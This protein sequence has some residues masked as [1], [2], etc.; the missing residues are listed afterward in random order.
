MEC[1]LP[2]SWHLALPVLGWPWASLHVTGKP[3]GLQGQNAGFD[4]RTSPSTLGTWTSSAL[5]AYFLISQVEIIVTVPLL[6]LFVDNLGNQWKVFSWLSGI[7]LAF[8]I[9]MVPQLPLTSPVA[10]TVKS[11]PA[12]QETQ[13]LSLGQEDPLEKEIATHSNTLAWKIPWVEEPG[14]LQSM[15]SQRAGHNWETSLTSQL[16]FLKMGDNNDP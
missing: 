4:S 15:G 9:L 10:Q 8:S 14:R 16:P 11:L 6:E 2:V 3:V 7:L 13:V 12:V 5:W 1:G